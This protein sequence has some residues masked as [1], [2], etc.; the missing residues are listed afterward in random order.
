MENSVR[1][2][3]RSKFIVRFDIYDILY[4]LE[5]I[6]DVFVNFIEFFIYEKFNLDLILFYKNDNQNK[7]KN[8]KIQHA[9][10]LNKFKVC[11]FTTDLLDFAW[12]DIYNINNSNFRENFKFKNT[13]CNEDEFVSSV[14]TFI[15]F[16]KAMQ[17]KD[18]EKQ[19]ETWYSRKQSIRKKNE[20]KKGNLGTKKEI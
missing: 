1:E 11:K 14:F 5:D 9:D 7:I 17:N 8:F 10:L 2:I 18:E 16:I 4:N 15:S 6:D 20:Y 13:Y 3:E 19:N 12:Y